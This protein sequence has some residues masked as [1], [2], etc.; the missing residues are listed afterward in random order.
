MKEELEK[1]FNKQYK[2]YSYLDRLFMTKKQISFSM[3][4]E[5][6][7]YEQEKTTKILKFIKNNL[8]K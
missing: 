1:I 8:I 7:L 5:G 2:K 3:F 6:I 4:L